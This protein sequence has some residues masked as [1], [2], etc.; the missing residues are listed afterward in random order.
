MGRNGFHTY[1][2]I[3]KL[4]SG[5]SN[6]IIDIAK[7]ENLPLQVI[8]LDIDKDTSVLDAINEIVTENDRIDALV[9]NAA[10][11]KVILQAAD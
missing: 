8:Q 4:E 3:R 10:Y 11:A 5:W 9:N 2:T 1:A 7:N 6:Q